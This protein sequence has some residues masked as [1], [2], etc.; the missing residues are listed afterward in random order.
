MASQFAVFVDGVDTFLD[1]LSDDK[2]RLAAVQALNK[3][4]RDGRAAA[5]RQILREL[6][7]PSSYVAPGQG[8]LSVTQQASRGRLEAKITAQGRATSLARFVTGSPK[9][10]KPGLWVSVQPG[11]S[12]F[13]KK[14]FL[15]RL[16]QGN[17]AVTDTQFNLGLAVRLR[18][19]ETLAGKYAAR[20]VASG[21]YT[22]YGPS[23]SQIFRAND[24]SG[25]ATDLAPDLSERL[26]DEFVRL[27]GVR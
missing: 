10:G 11:G 5:A 14:A 13:L 2:R 20:R 6:N 24:G 8:R 9:P 12:K 17:S 22:L 1:D 23:V 15:I 25:V 19:G 27:L 7:V 4:A 16:P 18:P 26:A 3:I 21:L